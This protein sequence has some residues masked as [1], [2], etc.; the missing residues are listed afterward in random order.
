MAVFPGDSSRHHPRGSVHIQI[1]ALTRWHR[2]KQADSPE[3]GQLLVDLPHPLNVEAAG[4]GMVH[5]GLGVVHTHNAARH[6]LHLLG[7]VPRVVDVL[8]WEVFQDREVAP[9]E[10][11][12][13]ISASSSAHR[14]VAVEELLE[15]GAA[16]V[17]HPA[18][19]VHTPVCIQE[20]LLKHLSSNTHT[21]HTH[22]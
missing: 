14:T 12:V 11:A 8:G 17:T 9:N 10:F 6:P 13:G 21:H 19:S 22:Q 20:Q 3:A 16:G 2:R 1:L 4:L 15:E 5:H 18:A 7:G